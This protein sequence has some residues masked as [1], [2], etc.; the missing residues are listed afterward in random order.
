MAKNPPPPASLSPDEAGIWDATVSG[1]PRGHFSAEMH[2]ALAEYC[3]CTIAAEQLAQVVVVARETLL[4]DPM[5]ANVLEHLRK[6]S[7]V[8]STEVSVAS[9]L[10]NRLGI[11]SAAKARAGLKGGSGGENNAETPPPWLDY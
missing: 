7:Q 5:N 8:R 10:A 6:A 3:R 2:A 11:V 4:A 9:R 1:M